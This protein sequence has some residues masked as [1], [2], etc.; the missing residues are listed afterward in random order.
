VLTNLHASRSRLAAAI[1]CAPD[2]MLPAYLR[3]MERP[4][5]PRVVKTGPV[6]EVVLTGADVDLYALPQIVHH[7]G[8]AGPYVTAAISFAKDPESE[9]WNCAYNRLMI[10]GRDTTSIHL[11]LGKHL[12]EFNQIA[13]RRG[14][15]LQ[16][17]LVIG[18]HP[19]IALGAL[20]I[21]SI[22]EDERGIMGALLGE[23]LELVKCETSDVLVPAHA[24]MVLEAEILTDKRTPEGPFGEFTGYSLGERQREVVRIKAITHRRDAMFQDI[25]VAHLDHMLL[26]TIPMEA[27]LYRAVR[28]MVPSVRAVRVPAPF[29][30]YVSI[31]QRLPGQ[32]KNAIMAVL[33]ADLYMK[34]VVVVDHDVD[35]FDDRQVTWAIA[36]RCQPDRDLTIVT[37]ARGSDLDPSSRED[38][39]TAKWGVDATAKPSLGAYTPRHRIPPEVWERL[40]LEDF[41]P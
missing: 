40:R 19:A 18:V 21:G 20:A 5:P 24:E 37:H 7:Q 36:T 16:L 1:N 31:E 4:L 27:N 38:G 26:S 33:G 10:Q 8:D 17:A 3:A 12:W 23:P 13:E 15:P 14:E 11:T 39:Y 28:A 30:C 32:A 25:T 9:T 34:R 35:V 2:A 41:L 6:K 29:T 22:D